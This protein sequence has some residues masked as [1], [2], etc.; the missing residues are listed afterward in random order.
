M[1]SGSR[2]PLCYPLLSLLS[3]DIPVILCYPV[4]HIYVILL[5]HCQCGDCVR[6]VSLP[7]LGLSHV[8]VLQL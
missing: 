4:P 3:F 6:A 2:N 5:L 1:L 8:V 7:Y